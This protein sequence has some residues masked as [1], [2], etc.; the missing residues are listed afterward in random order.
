MIYHKI[1][2]CVNIFN[3]I[4]KILMATKKPFAYTP[5]KC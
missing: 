3:I 2:K 5:F 1:N 4:K